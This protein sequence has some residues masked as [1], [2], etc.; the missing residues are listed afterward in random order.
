MQRGARQDPSWFKYPNTILEIY[1]DGVVRVDLREPL[2]PAL[3]QELRELGLGNH[4]AVVT[5][6]NP[7][8]DQLTEEENHVRSEAFETRTSTRD[9]HFLR[10]DGVSVCGTH[11]ETGLALNLDRSAATQLA[12]EWG[13][14]GIFFFDGNLFWLLDVADEVSPLALPPETQDNA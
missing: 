1:R 13:Q 8:G 4:F 14:S 5:A 9:C 2:T 3:A 6:C 12:Q 10:A 11:R 7:T